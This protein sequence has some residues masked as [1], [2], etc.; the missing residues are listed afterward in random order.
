MGTVTCSWTTLPCTTMKPQKSNGNGTAIQELFNCILKQFLA[1]FYLKVFLQWYMGEDMDEMEFTE[2]ESNTNDLVS[3]YQQYQ[4]ATA[5]EEED[6]RE[7]VE[8]EA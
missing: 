1:M 6:S 5:E 3:K 2:A 4:G 7:E 8:E